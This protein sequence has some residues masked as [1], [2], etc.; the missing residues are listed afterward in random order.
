MTVRPAHPLS[1][2][3]TRRVE[4]RR[5]ETAV[6]TA[7]ETAVTTVVGTAVETAVETAVGTAV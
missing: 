6:G 5:G 3:E 2:G 4:T 7:V 1:T